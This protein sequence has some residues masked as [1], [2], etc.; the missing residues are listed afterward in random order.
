MKGQIILYSFLPGVTA[1]VLTTQPSWA[2]QVVN[3]N[4][5]HQR[6]GNNLVAESTNHQ[7]PTTINSSSSTNLLTT[8]KPSEPEGLK[9]INIQSFRTHDVGKI[10]TKTVGVPIGEVSFED[11]GVFSG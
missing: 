2:R 9:T 11:G 8:I 6:E 7:P 1:A 5:S 4:I 10:A 3:P